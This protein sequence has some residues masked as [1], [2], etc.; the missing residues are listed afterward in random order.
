MVPIAR[1]A[2]ARIV[3]VNDQ[4]TGMDAISDRF[5]HGSIGDVLPAICGA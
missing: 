3:I 5:L 4:P 2:G 1:D